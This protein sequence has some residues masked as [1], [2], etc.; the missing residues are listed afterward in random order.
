MIRAAGGSTKAAWLVGALLVVAILF[1]AQQLNNSRHTYP[2]VIRG[3]HSLAPNPGALP[4][5]PPRP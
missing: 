1:M 5:L 2:L 4:T 3:A